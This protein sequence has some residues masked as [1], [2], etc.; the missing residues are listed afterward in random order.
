MGRVSVK[1]Q[2]KQEYVWSKYKPP[3]NPYYELNNNNM[4]KLKKIVY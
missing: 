2:N 4:D 3:Y 1:K